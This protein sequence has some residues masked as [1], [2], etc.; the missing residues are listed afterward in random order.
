MLKLLTIVCLGLLTF[1]GPA[2]YQA[3]KPPG[4]TTELAVYEPVS[5]EALQ[6][7]AT[8][9]VMVAIPVETVKLTKQRFEKDATPYVIRKQ[10]WTGR[11]HTASVDKYDKQKTC[12]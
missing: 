6:A 10:R 4:I 3:D 7:P 1:A 9:V 8:T 11:I 2:N 5:I 12:S